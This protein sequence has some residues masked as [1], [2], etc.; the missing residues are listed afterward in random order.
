MAVVLRL[1]RIGKRTQPHYRIVAIEKT[2]GPRAQPLEVI[3]HYNP[4]AEKDK[5][6]VTI[7][8]EKLEYWQKNGAKPSET[9]KSLIDRANKAAARAEQAQ[10]EKK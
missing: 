7:N 1:Q 8:S 2:S 6:K 4:K 3:G 9:V 5:E 10:E